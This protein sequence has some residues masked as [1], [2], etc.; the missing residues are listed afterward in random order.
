MMKVKSRMVKESAYSH[1]A[2]PGSGPSLESYCSRAGS[3]VDTLS[4]VER[5]LLY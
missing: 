5:F 3:Y 1:V 2:E 4:Y